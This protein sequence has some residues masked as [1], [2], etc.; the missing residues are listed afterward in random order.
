M[1]LAISTL[2][3]SWSLI[4]RLPFLPGPISIFYKP[5]APHPSIRPSVGT[6]FFLYAPAPTLLCSHLAAKGHSAHRARCG[7]ACFRH[8]SRAQRAQRLEEGS[9]RRCRS[10]GSPSERNRRQRREVKCREQPPDR[11]PTCYLSR[12]PRGARLSSPASAASL[13]SLPPPTP[14]RRP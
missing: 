11:L 9:A 13:G 12:K 6:F 8:R 5:P 7:A 10:T 2:N 14:P 4:P 1:H 3:I